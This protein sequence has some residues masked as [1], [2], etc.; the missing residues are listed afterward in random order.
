MDTSVPPH[1]TPCGS[2]VRAITASAGRA[3]GR[4]ALVDAR[5]G[6]ALGY[7][8]L[9]DGM[10]RAA[11]RLRDAG[12]RVG[13]PVM[14]R[15]TNSLDFAVAVLGAI[16]AGA[17]AM[18]VNPDLTPTELERL[19]RHADARVALT[20]D[21]PVD[22]TS[23]LP[24]DVWRSGP[25]T[26][27]AETGDD[28]EAG[29]L[30]IYTSGTTGAPKGVML[31]HG[32][33]LANVS[34]A[35]ARLGLDA[36]HTTLAVLPLFHTFALV[37]D[38]LPMLVSGGTAVVAPAFDV[39]TLADLGAHVRGYGVRSFS[40]V[41]L[42]IE[43]LTRLGVDL[44]GGDLRFVVSGA[45]P[46]S[47]ATR[48]AFVESQGLPI[49]PAYGMTESCCFCAIS[50]PDAVVPGSCGIPV[51]ELRVLDDTDADCPAGTAGE[52]VIRGPEVLRHGYHRD[53]RPC[54][55]GSG[56]FRTG[57][58]GRVDLGGNLYITGRKKSMVVRGGEKV[59]LG[60]L[61]VC[62]KR[63]P[64]VADAVTVGVL[65]VEPERVVAFVVPK[66]GAI[67]TADIEAWLRG[68]VGRS[69]APDEVRFVERIPYTRT[70]KARLAELAERARRA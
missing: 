44:R 10:A 5:S 24:L 47:E 11:R 54:Y 45:A 7:P 64:S 36:S 62:L 26:D 48:T 42:A 14:L 34:R 32:A 4:P 8:A 21:G 19:R 1:T 15:G 31:T 70:G 38:V 13:D 57:D 23:R 2:L 30:L 33:L 41:P 29:A 49:V 28:P 55:V 39:T 59:Y 43:L 18:P 67:S 68:E 53:D 25:S 27:L 56:W 63:H 35:V 52:L 20:A 60:D 3:R 17:V 16:A 6:E 22:G 37:S 51:V 65:D 46:L 69:R 12:V 61:D 9:L 50:R 58:I 66:G 40:A